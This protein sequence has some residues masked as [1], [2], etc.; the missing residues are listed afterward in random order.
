[1]DVDAEVSIGHA[2][3][4]GGRRCRFGAQLPHQAARDGPGQHDAHRD[5]PCRRGQHRVPGRR[6]GLSGGLPGAFRNLVVVAIDNPQRVA[7][8]IDS[9][10]ARTQQVRGGRIL[11]L[12]ICGRCVGQLDQPLV[13]FQVR[14][15]LVRE[16]SHVGLVAF[17]GEQVLDVVVAGLAVGFQAPLEH[18]LL[19]ELGLRGPLHQVALISYRRFRAFCDH[20]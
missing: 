19:L 12:R 4:Q 3:S 11:L 6:I 5:G 10:Q 17:V 2:L 8:F 18:G 16:R 15:E 7:N 9:L 20:F 14:A 1:M 13:R